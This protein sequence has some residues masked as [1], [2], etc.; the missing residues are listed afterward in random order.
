MATDFHGVW[1]PLQCGTDQIHKLSKKVKWLWY[2]V[3]GSISFL[4]LLQEIATKWYLGAAEMYPLS[5]SEAESLRLR[6]WQRCVPSKGPGENLLLTSSGSCGPWTLFD[7]RPLC[8]SL[9]LC[10][11]VSSYSMPVF[12]PLCLIMTLVPGFR[13]YPG[14]Q[15]GVL[16]ILNFYGICK[17]PFS[18]ESNNHRFWPLGHEH[19][20]W[21]TST[22]LTAEGK[23]TLVNICI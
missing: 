3:G 11:H 8:C 21:G 14:H 19:V 1:V 23:C 17:D 18:K 15:D 6:F 22:Q 2:A 4:G 5:A 10:L 13:V 16:Q 7:L 20:F 9:C 12:S